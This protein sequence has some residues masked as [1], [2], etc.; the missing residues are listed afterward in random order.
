MNCD[1]NGQFSSCNPAEGQGTWAGLA[2]ALRRFGM[3][4]GLALICGAT[5]ALATSYLC[6]F[7]PHTMNR[8]IPEA[9]FLDLD[10]AKMIATV[11]DS[12]IKYVYKKPLEV[13]FTEVGAGRYRLS[14][15]V[16]H[17]PFR[18]NKSGSVIYTMNFRES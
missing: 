6:A 4:A 2:A 11:Y 18:G 5:P 16:D 3:A 12:R 14:W 13:P 9:V 8:T 1:V 10:K 17:L 7:T 15:R